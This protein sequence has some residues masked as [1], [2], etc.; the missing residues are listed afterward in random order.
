MI[1]G[2]YESIPNTYSDAN[3]E[4]SGKAAIFN[5][6][7]HVK[8]GLE[9]CFVGAFTRYRVYSGDGTLNQTPFDFD[10][11]EVTVGLNAGKRWILKNGFNFNFVIGYGIFMDKMD[12]GSS[13]SDVLDA[14]H[15]FQDD[16][17]LYNGLYG[18]LSIGFAF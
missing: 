8:H 5:Y 9:S 11:K 4:V 16:Y 1:R 14:I 7:Y 3:I 10:L 2:D 6:R 12:S 15:V 13:D 18:E 17:D